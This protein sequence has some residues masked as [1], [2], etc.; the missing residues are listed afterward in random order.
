MDV[1]GG[2][3][4][5]IAPPST[6]ASGQTYRWDDPAGST[7]PAEA[8]DW[9]LELLTKKRHPNSKPTPATAGTVAIPEGRR[10]E[11]LA[12]LAGKLR[13]CG[14]DEE[15]IL[16]TLELENSAR[17]EPPLDQSEVEAIARSISHYPAGKRTYLRTDLGNAERLVDLHGR[18]LC[19]APALGWF[20]W[21]SKRWKPDSDGEAMRR[22]KNTA[23]RIWDEARATENPGEQESLYKYATR[24]ESEPK[25]RAALKLAE[26]EKP[27]VVNA[28]DLDTDPWLLNVSNGTLDLRTG[29]LR[30]HSRGDLLT[31]LSAVRYDPDTRS[32]LWEDFLERITGSDRELQSFLQR[33]AGYSLTGKTS[34]EKLFFAHGPAASGKSTFMESIKATLGQYATTVDFETFLKRKGDSGVRNDIARLAGARIAIGAEVD[35]GKRLAEGLLKTLTGGDTVS[36][37]FLYKEFFEFRPQFK[38]W[39][40]ANARPRV[41][42]TDTGIWRRITQMPFTEVIPENERDPNLK[43]ELKTDPEAQSAILNWALEGCRRWQQNGLQVPERVKAYTEEYREENDPLRDFFDERCAFAAEATVTRK[44]L[45]QAYE[46]WAQENGERPVHPKTLAS[47]LG[48]R[49]GT[50]GPEIRGERSWHGIELSPCEHNGNELDPLQPAAW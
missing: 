29:E 13:S 36:A 39:L 45:L 17:C 3:G 12:S 23:K 9:L 15:Q 27:I 24:S 30:E 16:E 7:R 28:Q 19:F 20:V 44:D 33:A 6:H 10:N 26:T 41:S 31:K 22:M 25:L 42:A 37:R 35:E 4:Y 32:A 40:A 46:Q 50:E 11:T 2:G 47:A 34:E 5:V 18:D 43:H 21:D 14:A 8:P 1:C 38:L 48:A 49:G